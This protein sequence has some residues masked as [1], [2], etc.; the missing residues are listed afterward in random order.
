MSETIFAYM[1]DGAQ[2][3][4]NFSFDYLRKEFV[5]VTVNGAVVP[6]VFNSTYT[7]KITPAPAAGAAILIQRQ[8]DTTK[9][10]EFVDGSV[11]L[12]QDMN[13]AQTQ[14][15]HI[16]AEALD[17]AGGEA[18]LATA[19][20]DNAIIAENNAEAAAVVATT[21]AGIATTRTGEVQ[22]LRDEVVALGAVTSTRQIATGSGLAGGGDLAA[23]RTITVDATVLRTTAEQTIAGGITAAADNDGTA[24]PSYTPTPVGGNFKQLSVA[25]AVTL[26]APVVAGN[27]VLVIDI[28]LATGAGAITPAG[29]LRTCGDPFTTTVGHKFQAT[30]TKTVSGCSLAVLALQ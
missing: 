17:V 15:I 24:P 12:A 7:L 27:Y 3:D 22:A 13:V 10:V 29:F 5:K 8:T 16:S 9:L 20:M 19:A 25:S 26:N 1:G 2:T 23:D 4:F 30:I 6:F 14:A 21:Q 18:A 11:L 28:T